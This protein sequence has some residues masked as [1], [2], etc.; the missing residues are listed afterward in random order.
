MGGGQS[1]KHEHCEQESQTRMPILGTVLYGS[2]DL[3]FSNLL[4]YILSKPSFNPGSVT[5]LLST[6][7]QLSVNGPLDLRVSEVFPASKFYPGRHFLKPMIIRSL[8][9]TISF[10]WQRR[11]RCSLETGFCA[12][13]TAFLVRNLE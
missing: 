1:L 12:F 6:S 7:R 5:N 9:Y 13:I 8:C 2:L 11:N 3:K 4:P 10:C